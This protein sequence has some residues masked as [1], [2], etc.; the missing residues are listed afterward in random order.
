VNKSLKQFSAIAKKTWHLRGISMPLKCIVDRFDSDRWKDLKR[1]I[2][3]YGMILFG[4]YREL[5]EGLRHWTMVSF[6]TKRLKSK[7]KVRIIRNLYGYQTRKK[8]KIY[9]HD[10]IV[11]QLNGQ[12]LG[13]NL[14]LIPI[15]NHQKIQDF[16][17]KEKIEVK[18][19]ECFMNL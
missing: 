18:T 5:P 11:K 19:R 15:E 16:F 6:E 9:A 8:T 1:D 2:I 7:N 4:K 12:K 10:G 17:R 3:S 13:E 14:I